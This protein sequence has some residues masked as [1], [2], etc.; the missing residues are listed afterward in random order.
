MFD[1]KLLQEVTAKAQTWLSDSYDEQTRAQVQAMLDNED[2]TE[3]VESF[4]KTHVDELL[5][6]VEGVFLAA[7]AEVTAADFVV[8]GVAVVS[9]GQGLVV[10]LKG[11]VIFLHVLVF[12][13]DGV[14]KLELLV[15]VEVGQGVEIVLQRLFRLAQGGQTGAEGE[16]IV[17]VLVVVDA[18]H[19]LHDV[20]GALGIVFEQV[21]SCHLDF[22]HIAFWM[23]CHGHL[24][25][26]TRAL[27]LVVLGVVVDDVLKFLA[28]EISRVV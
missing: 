27:K 28:V 24:H 6:K 15:F 18:F 26:L 1:E 13:G 2:K 8:D 9:E 22:Q 25:R 20:E 14:V 19:V 5:E 7:C 17:G 11:E 4:Y 23:L 21:L 12:E 10:K 16:E 3:L